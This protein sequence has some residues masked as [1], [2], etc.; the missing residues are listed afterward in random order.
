MSAQRADNYTHTS[1]QSERKAAVAL[2][3]AYFGDL[4]PV[5]PNSETENNKAAIQ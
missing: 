5:V 1:R 4:F 3:Q 2:E